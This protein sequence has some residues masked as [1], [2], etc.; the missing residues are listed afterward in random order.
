[1]FEDPILATDKRV[2]ITGATSGIGF[3]TARELAQREAHV[4]IACRNMKKCTKIA[5]DII[6]D[7]K[8]ENVHCL[9]CDLSSMESIRKFVEK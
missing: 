1:M 9:E 5:N 6:A 3:E 8:N 2:I 4:Y 7:T